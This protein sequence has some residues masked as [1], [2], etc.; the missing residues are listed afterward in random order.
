M[1]RKLTLCPE[2]KALCLGK[3]PHNT[4]MSTTL[5][6]F[7]HDGGCIMLWVCLSSARTRELC[8]IKIN[9]IEL[10]TGKILEEVQ[11]A[12]QQTLGDKFTFQQ[13]NNLKQKA[14]YPLE[15]LTKKT[16]NVPEWPSYSFDLN[17]LENLCQDLKMAV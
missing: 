1:T 7:K 6:I 17:L 3:I 4:S 16:W 5:H 9:R 10:S 14:M 11:S 15:L 8:R 12:F 13:N 2:H